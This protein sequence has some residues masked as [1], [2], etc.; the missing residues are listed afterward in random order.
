MNVMKTTYLKLPILQ[1]GYPTP[2]WIASD[3]SALTVPAFS[4][5]Q[6]FSRQSHAPD[7]FCG[8]LSLIA[9]LIIG[10]YKNNTFR[11]KK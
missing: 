6:L 9:S 4:T 2:F 5:V 7:C 11:M 1:K 3:Y 10:A 8:C